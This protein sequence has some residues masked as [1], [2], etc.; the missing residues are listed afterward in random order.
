MTLGLEAAPRYGITRAW[1]MPNAETFDVPPIAA[2][3]ERWHRPPSVDPFARNNLWATYRNDLSPATAAE[4]HMEAAD[5]C[6][7]LVERGVRAECVL[8]DPPYSPR[9]I[10][11]VYQSIGRAVGTADTQSPR[12]YREV[13]DELDRLLVPGG[14]ALSFGWN[15]AGF[16]RERGYTVAEILLVA[17]GGAHNDTICVAEIKR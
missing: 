5:F 10:S 4:Y 1:A 15:S 6:R 3:L 17:H 11:E 9:Q 7:Q 8:F 16:G 2:F 12:L 13:R 14:V